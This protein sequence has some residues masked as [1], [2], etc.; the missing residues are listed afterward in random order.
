MLITPI[1]IIFI[2][3]WL[4]KERLTV[5]KI[6]GVI[7]GVAGATILIVMKDVSHTASNIFLGD[8]L[9]I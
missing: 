4:L 1:L 2:A 8:V 9:V 7:V 3:A 6:V 5:L